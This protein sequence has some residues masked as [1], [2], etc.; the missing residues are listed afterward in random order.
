L[1]GGSP[2]LVTDLIANHGDCIRDEVNHCAAHLAHKWEYWKQLQMTL[3]A[4]KRG[5]MKSN[6]HI[7][8]NELLFAHCLACEMAFIFM[9]GEE[10]RE[11]ISSTKAMRPNQMGP[12]NDQWWIVSFA[13]EILL[14]AILVLFLPYHLLAVAVSN[15]QTQ[16]R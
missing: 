3:C 11:F 13:F 5:T 6:N 9:E 8:G 7:L 14:L 2:Q 1:E 12:K 10:K 15:C 4:I 16:C